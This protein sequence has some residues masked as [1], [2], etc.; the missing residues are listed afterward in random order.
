MAGGYHAP[1]PELT[2]GIAPQV[3]RDGVEGPVDRAGGLVEGDDRARVTAV[4]DPEQAH[5]DGADVHAVLVDD[6]LDVDA[7]A[8][9]VHDG[10]APHDG[11]SSSVERGDVASTG[12]GEDQ[13]AVDRHAVRPDHGQPVQGEV[14]RPCHLAGAQVDRADASRQVL[15]VH[16]PVDDDRV[17]GC[18]AERAA[19]GERRAPRHLEIGDVGPVD[20]AVGHGA[21]VAVVA[22]GL[23]PPLG[24]AQRRRSHRDA[25]AC[26]TR[27]ART[28]RHQRR[29]RDR[30]PPHPSP[31]DG[32][33]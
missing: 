27:G 23:Q 10:L 25:G 32:R 2:V 18:I 21:R 20:R 1:P 19:A 24:L 13:A 33:S 12:D 15:E 17:G 26:A 30:D 22:V 4:V 8:G 7:E 14:G 6:G 28:G 31:H 5:G 11:T 3:V 9:G 16:L 29:D